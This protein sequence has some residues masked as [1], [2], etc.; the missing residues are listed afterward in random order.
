MRVLLSAYSCGP[1]LGS[2]PSV[3]WNTAREMAR[4]HDVWVLTSE[5]HRK[6]IEA[7]LRQRPVTSLH[8]I[9]LDCPVWLRAVLRGRLG[10]VRYYYW[11]LAAYHSARALHARV[12][13]DVAHH[14]TFCRYWTPSFLSFLPVPFVWG[15]VGGGE[16]APRRFW[17]GLGVRGCAFEAVREL[18]RY[19]GECDPFLRASARR[20]TL[21]LATTIETQ[22]RMQRL[23]APL[24]EVCASI[25]LVERDLADLGRF[26][27]PPPESPVRFVSMGRMLAWKGFHLAL[28]GFARMN[29]PQAEYWIV[30]G[31]PEQWALVDLARAL[32]ISER[33]RFFGALPRSEALS[34]LARCHVLVHPSLHDSGGMVCVEAMAARRP[35]ICL[36]LGGPALVVTSACGFK[37][38]AVDPE[39]AIR[40]LADAMRQLAGSQALRKRMGD[41]A[42]ERAKAE[43]CSRA[44]GRQLSAV[45]A[46]ATGA[47]RP[48]ETA[49]PEG[50]SDYERCQIVIED[51]LDIK[52]SPFEA[53]SGTMRGT[54]YE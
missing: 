1:G 7:E 49:T 17:S 54:A 20:A 3:G 10:E 4:D 22:K 37:I 24:V 25:S 27:F 11:Q 50:R 46:R 51:D 18:A 8:F 9:F 33:V 13:F 38:P 48:L 52:S 35:V 41:A 29:D 28:R 15:P 39:V 19:V 26:E 47:H 30:G 34:T 43:F 14:V 36:D 45:Y 16:S 32:G 12:G 53:P 42:R 2:E 44:R 31:G 23:N 40:G 6:E 21:A 5:L